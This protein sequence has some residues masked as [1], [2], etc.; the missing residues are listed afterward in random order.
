MF[1]GAGTCVSQTKTRIRRIVVPSPT[2]KPPTRL[3]AVLP[4]CGHRCQKPRLIF[5]VILSSPR[6]TRFYVLHLYAFG[7]TA[8]LPPVLVTRMHNRQPYR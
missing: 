2:K 1:V 6:R 4:V 3:R 7:S 5:V 8:W